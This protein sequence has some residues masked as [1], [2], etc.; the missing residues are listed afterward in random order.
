MGSVVREDEVPEVSWGD[1]TVPRLP[2]LSAAVISKN[3]WHEISKLKSAPAWREETGRSSETLAK[4]SGFSVVLVLMK[5][6]TQMSTHH[7]DGTTSLYVIQGR[8]RIHL[9]DEQVADLSVGEFLVLGPGLQHDVHA[10]EESAFLLTVAGVH[11]AI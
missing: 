8:I 5:A 11:G 4:S 6:G 2:G 10:G 7:A 1:T 3:V 9:P